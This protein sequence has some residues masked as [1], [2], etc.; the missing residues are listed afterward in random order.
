MTRSHSKDIGKLFSNLRSSCNYE[1][2]KMG[3]F[4]KYVCVTFLDRSVH[5]Y[6]PFTT[7]FI[8]LRKATILP[9]SNPLYIAVSP[10]LNGQT[11]RFFFEQT[12]SL[13]A[14]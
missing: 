3:E 7:K 12:L 1:D 13:G 6:Q 9:I 14:R 8:E 11:F 10:K 5:Q 4:E 2:T